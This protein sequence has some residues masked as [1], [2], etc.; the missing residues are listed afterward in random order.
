MS[1]NF[2]LQARAVPK[3][4]DFSILFILGMPCTAIEQAISRIYKR[5]KYA[6]LVKRVLAILNQAHM[7]AHGV[8]NPMVPHM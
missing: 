5:L 3:S 6:T 1:I 8:L 7:V 2:T 4:A